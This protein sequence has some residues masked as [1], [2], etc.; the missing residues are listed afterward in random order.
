MTELCALK[1]QGVQTTSMGA[2]IV[3][4]V[5]TNMD[6]LVSRSAMTRMVLLFNMI[7]SNFI[8]AKRNKI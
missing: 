1:R 3:S 8:I 4:N 5:G 7:F 6:C 2:V